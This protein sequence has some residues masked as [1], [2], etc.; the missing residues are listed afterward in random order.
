MLLVLEPPHHALLALVLDLR[1]SKVL[2]QLVLVAA[3]SSSSELSSPEDAQRKSLPRTPCAACGGLRASLTASLTPG[4]WRRCSSACRLR[5]SPS[6]IRLRTSRSVD[7]RGAGRHRPDCCQP[8]VAHEPG[9]ADHD[10]SKALKLE[11]E[12]YAHDQVQSHETYTPPVSS[13]T[14][15]THPQFHNLR[16]SF[17]TLGPERRGEVLG[18]F[19]DLGRVQRA[20]SRAR[21]SAVSGVVG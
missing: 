4:L 18:R 7:C 2:L 10:A 9:K 1:Q 14:N 20:K 15:P 6:A 5:V 21:S 8:L 17:K 3:A 19:K 13:S 16:S 12:T 11:T